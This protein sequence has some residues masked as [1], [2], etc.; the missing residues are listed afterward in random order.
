[1]ATNTNHVDN[2]GVYVFSND[3]PLSGDILEHFMQGLCLDLFTF[4]LGARVIEVK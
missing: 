1:M 4:E 2:L 3:V